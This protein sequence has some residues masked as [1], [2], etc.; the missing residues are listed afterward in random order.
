MTRPIDVLILES[1]SGGAQAAAAE[2]E[3]AGHTVHRCHDPGEPA[4]PCRGV[5]DPAGCPLEGPIDVA[6]VVRDHI[7]RDPTALESGV[8]CALR[9]GV[10]VVEDGP[11][12]LDPFAPWITFRVGNAS[13]AHTCEQAVVL[14]YEPLL[15]DMRRRCS[16][17]FDAAGI[18]QSQVSFRAELDWPKLQVH[19]EVPEPVSGGVREALAVR[20]LDAVRAGRRTYHTVNV[21]V[22]EVA[23]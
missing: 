9:A 22:R 20:A 18:D 8:A 16:P 5:V 12:D 7:D 21:Q 15:D 11:A 17:L 6:L 13:V 23:D 4:F 10:P 1:R 14:S 19:L 3:A 2:L